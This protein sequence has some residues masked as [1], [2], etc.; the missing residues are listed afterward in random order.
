MAYL[1][2]LTLATGMALHPL[3]AETP[4]Q[5]ELVTPR[6]ILTLAD[7]LDLAE[8]RNPH[9]Q[10]SSA[11][12]EEASAAVTTASAYA[13][14]ELTIGSMGRQRAIQL[15][16]LPGMLHGFVMSQRVELPNVRST[17]ITA[18]RL[19]R[20][21]NQHSLESTTLAVRGFV[22]QTF[23]EA[24]RR[25]EEIRITRENLQLLEDLHRRI[26]VQ[27][28]VGEA[29]M[30]E[31]TR[32]QAEVASAM[33]QSQSAEMRY[34]TALAAL[35]SAVGAPLGEV[36]LQEKLD[37]LTPVPRL[38]L[39]VSEV[40]AKHPIIAEAQ[41]EA[42]RAGA[43]LN[44][45][46]ALKMPQ[47]TFWADVLEQP[48]VA[49]YRFGMSLTLPVWNRREGPIAEAVAAQRRANATAEARKLE[50]TA[51]LERAYGQYRVAQA[52]VQMFESGTI[53]QAE[54][55]VR[56]AEA[57]FKFGERGII[58]VLDA[59]RVLRSA[60][61]DYLNAQFDRQQALIELEQLGAVELMSGRR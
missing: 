56:G 58:E 30:L 6:R 9:L 22:K 4:Q 27:V 21:A 29:P 34:S 50:V 12:V 32:A 3:L 17:R 24:L 54:A 45:E 28:D 11:R 23:F 35:H 51:A 42:R 2:F 60:R 19:S 47:P 37:P 16:T 25:R 53:L 44:H 18:A 43:V 1:V 10:I 14:P 52:Q 48:D 26:R 31:L 40:L 59:Q 38:E 41:A 46:R 55:A 49:Q 33:I 20:E 5:T 57:A 36:E 13:N 15:G 8:R 39:L 61:Q 7:A